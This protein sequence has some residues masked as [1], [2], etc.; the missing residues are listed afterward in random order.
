[1]PNPAGPR[2]VA[3]S[4]GRGALRTWL[5]GAAIVA[6]S[7]LFDVLAWP[8]FHGFLESFDFHVKPFLDFTRVYY[9]MAKVLLTERTPIYG[10]YYPPFFALLLV[11]LTALSVESA[12]AVWA[13]LEILLTGALVMLPARWFWRRAGS[14]VAL[15]YTALVAFSQPALHNFRW[16]QVSVPVTLCILV[17][18][19]LYERG[20][21]KTAATVLAFA[22]AVK[23]YPAFFGLYFLIRRDFRFLVVT[24]VLTIAFAFGLPA[25]AIGPLTT[26]HFFQ[27]VSA[28][29]SG[30]V[31]TIRDNVGSQNLTSAL[32][33]AWFWGERLDSWRRIFAVLSTLLAASGLATLFVMRHRIRGGEWAPAFALLFLLLPAALETCWPHYFVYLPFCQTVAWSG[34]TEPGS[35]RIVQRGLTLASVLLST[36]PLFRWENNFVVFYGD[37]FL[38][39]ADLLLIIPIAWQL[40]PREVKATTEAAASN[41]SAIPV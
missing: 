14:A 26:V 12:R 39:A 34:A 4:S 16:G 25:M 15:L 37:G 17:T 38:A 5:L 24:A 19:L 35:R 27:A 9:A 1:L 2:T 18:A 20:R 11:P 36:T 3:T 8:T 21:W 32:M 10:Y 29:V 40:L 23:A 33:H 13:V 41:S 31:A 30:E 6:A 28:M 7:L 22:C